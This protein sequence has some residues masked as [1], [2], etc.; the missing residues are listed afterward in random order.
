MRKTLAI[1][2][3]ALALLLAGCG[4]A[5]HRSSGDANKAGPPAAGPA[6]GGGAVGGNGAKA[7]DPNGLQAPDKAGPTERYF[8]PMVD[9]AEDP[10]STFALD[11]DTAS[12]SYARDLIQSGQLPQPTAVRPEEFI[13]SFNQDYPQPGGNGFTV[14]L[15]GSRLPDGHEIEA[16]GDTRL[17]R[18]GLRTRGDDAERPDATLTFVIDVSGSMSDP[19]KLTLVKAALHKLVGTLRPTDS[20][21]VVTFNT[22]ADVLLA[23]TSA[24]RRDTVNSAIDRLTASGGTD[25]GTGLVTG[26]ETARKGFRSGTTNRVVLLS[27]GLANHGDT[28]ADKI[29]DQVR[30]NAAKQITLLGVGVGRDYGDALM[31]QLADRGDGFVI[32]VSDQAKAEDLFVRTLPATL[33]LRALDAKAQVTFNPATV[34]SYRLIG[35]DDR[36]LADSD[37][38][39]DH[40]DGGEVAAGHTVTALYAVRL[41]PGASGLV[42]TADVR[43]LDPHTRAAS[44]TTNTVSAG[45]LA[46]PF[47]Q[48]RPRLQVGYAAAYFAEVL[49][50]SPYGSEVSLAALAR[51]AADAAEQTDD[52]AVSDLAR[53]ITLADEHR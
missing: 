16:A 24:S 42:A 5:D 53:T 49:R 10:Q 36:A 11:V 25:L 48:A 7:A 52:P 39:N 26:Y 30:E 18:V 33:T 38:R 21:A 45:D 17:F 23:M 35:Y 1:T 44:E 12:Y 29:L 50:R 2:A 43:W 19:G 6:V 37:F 31:E 34:V 46:A 40:V 8:G 32:Y 14:T 3:A 9:A 22:E 28:G 20:V 41:R 27:D 4:A 47:T 13:N 51:I 15:D